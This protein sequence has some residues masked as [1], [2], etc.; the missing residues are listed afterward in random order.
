MSNAQKLGEIK[1]M[2]VEQVHAQ[3]AELEGV[4][5]LVSQPTTI[6]LE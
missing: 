5:D 3:V 6:Y 2:G 1:A 4:E